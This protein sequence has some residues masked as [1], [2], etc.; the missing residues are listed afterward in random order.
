MKAA[1]WY[2]A[3]GQ[4]PTSNKELHASGATTLNYS[5]LAVGLTGNGRCPRTRPPSRRRNRTRSNAELPPLPDTTLAVC[6]R[7]RLKR[8]NRTTVPG[9]MPPLGS[10]ASD[11]ALCAELLDEYRWGKSRAGTQWMSCSRS[12]LQRTYL[13]LSWN[14]VAD[15]R[16]Q[17]RTEAYDHHWNSGSMK[18][19]KYCPSGTTPHLPPE[20]WTP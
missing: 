4:V 5:H 17:P 6:W 14:S 11:L 9:T 3:A 16:I 15:V 2:M 7:G 13:I 12:G 19:M 8:A 20:E 18:M 1:K 10:W